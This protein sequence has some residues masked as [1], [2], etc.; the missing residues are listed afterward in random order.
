MYRVLGGLRTQYWYW[1]V[2]NE[3]IAVELKKEL[4]PV[5]REKLERLKIDSTIGHTFSVSTVGRNLGKLFPYSNLESE[6]SNNGSKYKNGERAVSENIIKQVE[7]VLPGSQLAYQNGPKGLFSVLEAPNL[8]GALYIIAK[9]LLAIL[10]S[11]EE[12]LISDV[13]LIEFT[14]LLS[15]RIKLNIFG[16]TIKL[17]SAVEGVIEYLIPMNGWSEFVPAIFT[18]KITVG[19]LEAG[20]LL[21]SKYFKA[22]TVIPIVIGFAFFKAKYFDEIHYLS[23]VCYQEQYLILMNKIFL[24][25][26]N[27]WQFN[28]PQKAELR[29]YRSI[30]EA[31]LKI[32]EPNKEIMLK[33]DR[34]FKKSIES[35]TCD[36]E[37]KLQQI[38]I[39]IKDVF[40]QAYIMANP[41]LFSD[42]KLW[43]EN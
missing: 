5:K 11:E 3:L 8:V 40:Q 38:E 32:D 29:K 9:E 24:M 10:E 30:K 2:R 4:K 12:R 6:F 27:T 34:N 18:D 23:K 31:E 42:C 28:L 25:D 22:K 15:T 17:L 35:M 41:V 43:N 7:Q 13:E 1:F 21:Q 19:D 14:E 16:G 36:D 37:S 20:N 39:V 33:M 26:E